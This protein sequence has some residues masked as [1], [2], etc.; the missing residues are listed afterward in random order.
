M[1][2]EQLGMAAA[3]GVTQFGLEQAGNAINMR[4]Q[5][6]YQKKI[7]KFNQELA[8]DLWQKTGPKGTMEQL[9]QAGLN[10]G[11]VYG[12]GG[13]AGGTTSGGAGSGTGSQSNSAQFNLGMGLQL[14]HQKAM[15]ENTKA[16]TEVKKADAAKTAGVDTEE[17]KGRIAAIAAETQN[18][19]IQNQLL[20]FDSEL[21]RIELEIADKSKDARAENPELVNKQLVQ[22]TEKII[23]E[24]RGAE[25]EGKIKA[26]T[27]DVVIKQTRQAAVEQQLRID[28]QRAG[29]TNALKT[30]DKI[31]AEIAAVYTDMRVKNESVNQRDF[32]NEI[33]DRLARLAEKDVDFRTGTGAQ[34]ERVSRIIGNSSGSILKLLGKSEKSKDFPKTK[35]DWMSQEHWEHINNN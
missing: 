24:T 6:K 12:M 5:H 19:G 1:S 26:E 32:E 30:T 4:R 31:A 29:L 35:P 20:A 18:K 11:L 17:S 2:W 23:A 10:P 22:A 13:A 7:N 27:M 33:K 3:Q 9:K 34:A 25:A 21:K 14:E 8:Y 16:D 15:I 28:L